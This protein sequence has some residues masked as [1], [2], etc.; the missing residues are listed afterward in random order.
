MKK[1]IS[2]F[3]F[4]IITTLSFG[5]ATIQL[6]D[7][8]LDEYNYLKEEKNNEIN[9]LQAV[10]VSTIDPIFMKD[11]Y[12]IRIVKY[13]YDT[14]FIAGE[15]GE[16]KPNLVDEFSWKEDRILV[17]KIKENIYFHDGKKLDSTGVKNS[18]ERMLKKGVFKSL[19]NDVEN[20][21]T[22]DEDTLE[23]KLKGKNNLFISMLSYYMC[24]ITKENENGEIIGTGPY[25]IGD[26][27]NKQ[28]VLLKNKKYFKGAP[29]ADKIT[30]SYE[31]SDRGRMISY[32]NEKADVVSDITLKRLEKWKKDELVSSDVEVLERDEIDT[33]SI[34]F[35]KKNGMFL[36][37]ESREAIRRI[38]DKEEISE[39]IFGEKSAETFFPKQLFKAKLSKINFKPQ[40]L[41]YV[42]KNKKIEITILNDDISMQVAE[43]VKTQLESNGFEVLIVP[44]QQE[45][46]LMKM[47]NKDYELAIYSILFDENYLIYNLGKVM[48]FDIGNNEM[49]N[50]TQPFLDIMRDEDKKDN[51]DKIYDKVVSLIAKDVP[52]IPLIHSKKIMIG[53]IKAKNLGFEGRD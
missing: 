9:M 36:S 46:Y 24:S 8:S 51:R 42:F 21:K 31:V 43:E 40:K 13:L 47:E 7:L 44:Y 50:A 17:L 16:I 38:I 14:L 39:N 19:F 53:N 29:K 49:Y 45:A 34:M 32:Y 4:I 15:N 26:I 33:T 10:K 18:L 22:I 12:S 28:L 30:I 48:L 37:R 25:E 1:Y 27:K 41:D 3:L 6:D 11:Q 35:G 2:I 5:G 20:I 23:I 52:Y